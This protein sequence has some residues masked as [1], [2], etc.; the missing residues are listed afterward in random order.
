MWEQHVENH[1]YLHGERRG[2]MRNNLL[3]CLQQNVPKV[4]IYIQL[5]MFTECLTHRSRQKWWPRNVVVTSSMYKGCSISSLLSNNG[6]TLLELYIV[7]CSKLMHT[8]TTIARFQRAQSGQCPT[9]L[10][11]NAM[12]CYPWL[13][14]CRV[15]VVRFTFSGLHT[16]WGVIPTRHSSCALCCYKDKSGSSAWSPTI[17]FLLH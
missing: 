7:F 3:L 4:N 13:S 14:L 5:C 16:I 15:V 9:G 8:H 2:C 6:S 12:A 10:T 1:S 11:A 17:H